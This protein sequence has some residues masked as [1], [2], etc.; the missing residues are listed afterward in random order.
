MEGRLTF[1][2]NKNRRITFTRQASAN[3]SIT[4]LLLYTVQRWARREWFSWL[5]V[6]ADER[7]GWITHVPM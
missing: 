7:T 4:L 2:F 6:Y 3:E 1:L 5:V